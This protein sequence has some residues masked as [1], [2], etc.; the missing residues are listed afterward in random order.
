MQAQRCNNANS[1]GPQAGAFSRSLEYLIEPSSSDEC[2]VY[3]ADSFFNGIADTIQKEFR[4]KP[5]AT[6]SPGRIG[7]IT[8][9]RRHFVARGNCNGT[10]LQL[11]IFTV[12][13]I[14]TVVSHGM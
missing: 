6:S 10:R 5:C 11:I 7:F 2:N 14:I 12:L 1:P 13:I 3:T 4:A 9:W 8:G